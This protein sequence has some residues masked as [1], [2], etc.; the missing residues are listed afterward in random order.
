LTLAVRTVEISRQRRGRARPDPGSPGLASLTI[1]TSN[2]R[3]AQPTEDSLMSIQ[4]SAMPWT[5]SA[6]LAVALS[7]ASLAAHAAS[8]CEAKAAEKKLAGAAKTSLVKKCEKDSKP[9]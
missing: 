6:L 7:V 5:R 9:G 8:P 1:P 4:I 3:V 2:P